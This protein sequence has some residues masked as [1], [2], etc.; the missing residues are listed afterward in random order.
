MKIG[1]VGLG[2]MGSNM[3]KRLLRNGHEVVVYDP[4]ISDNKIVANGEPIKVNSIP[5]LVDNLPLSSIVWLMVPEGNPVKENIL[6]LT[7]VLKAGDTIVDGG[8]SNWSDASI[9]AAELNKKGINFI[10]CGTSGGVWGLENGYCLMVGGDKMAC[11][12]LKP[13]FSSLAQ[14]NGFL[15][16]GPSGA[17]HFVKMVH[18]GIEYGMMQAYAEGFEVME[19]SSFNLDMHEISKV[20]QNGSVVRS[21]LL[22]LAGSLFEE[23]P[24]LS[25]IKDY[26][27]DSGEGRWMV[28][29]AIDLNVPA[30]VITLSLLS[31]LRSRQP[32][33]FSMKVLAGLRNRFGGHAIKSD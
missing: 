8:N 3:V 25:Q 12:N 13:I 27:E 32:E 7:K 11:N 19:K 18:N 17:G 33:S 10:D 1:F 21:W 24:K 31:R 6:E 16:C 14:E 23:D 22:E 20:W 30:P 15:Y 2:K 9:H 28:Q 5:E 4:N 26:V 29:T